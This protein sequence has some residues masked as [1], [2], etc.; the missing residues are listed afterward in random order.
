M[1]PQRHWLDG[2]SLSIATAA[3]VVVLIGLYLKSDPDKHL[4]NFFGN[5]IADWSGSLVVIL[6]TKYFY[7]VGSKESK[8]PKPD[9]LPPFWHFCHMHSLTIVLV[10]TLMGWIYVYLKMDPGSRWGQVVGN[11]VSEWTQIIG[12]VLLT[13]HMVERGAKT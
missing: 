1:K 2:H 10:I 3:I 9:A 5:A 12:L 11:L 13:K 4:G 6:A 7:E 8:K